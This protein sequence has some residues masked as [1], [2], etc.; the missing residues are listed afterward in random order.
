MF[1]N[2]CE[3]ELVDPIQEQSLPDS[4]QVGIRIPLSLGELREDFDKKGGACRVYDIVWNPNTLKK[5]LED[6]NVRK[7]VIE[8][9]MDHLKQKKG[10]P[11]IDSIAQTRSKIIG[12][13]LPKMKYKGKTVRLQRIKG[14]KAPKIEEIKVQ[15]KVAEKVMKEKY[16]STRN[17][18][19]A[20]EERGADSRVEA[21]RRAERVRPGRNRRPHSGP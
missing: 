7:A 1:I 17:N 8:L 10:L 21:V 2:M 20:Q 19:F 5:A 4:D 14:K 16:A 6:K 13:T 15:E 3:H 12:Y 18:D 11:L 9:A